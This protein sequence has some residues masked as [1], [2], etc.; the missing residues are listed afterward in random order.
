M[1]GLIA[2]RP[3]RALGLSLALVAALPAAWAEAD[4]QKKELVTK[5][6][7]LQ[8]NVIEG[9]AEGLVEQPANQLLQQADTA[10]QSRV[11]KDKQAEVVKGV[12]ADIKKY[13][14]DTSPIIKAK[15]MTLAPSTIG[16]MLEEKFSKDE[17]KQLITI[18]ESPVNRRLHEMG[19]E[20]QRSLSEKLVSESRV[21]I[22]PKIR[23]LQGNLSKR[24]GANTSTNAST[25]TDKAANT[26]PAAEP[27]PTTQPSSK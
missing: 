16:K 27:A 3:L 6:L 8:Q 20:M 24:F 19:P 11:P 2:H 21:D 9:L 4:A 13:L 18:L 12:R 26:A 14:D 22:E 15:A 1:I 17:L 25:N 5:L 7:K 23:E 10:L